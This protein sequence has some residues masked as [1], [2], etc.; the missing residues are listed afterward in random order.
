VELRCSRK[1]F[2][3]DSST[4]TK[5]TVEARPKKTTV[6]L[7]TAS[8]FPYKI[9]KVMSTGFQTR[10]YEEGRID[11][12][13]LAKYVVVKLGKTDHLIEVGCS[14]VVVL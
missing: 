7:M 5:R 10:K 8:L 3:S 4:R 9:G 1:K 14:A 11:P 6:V 13:E 12:V 2:I